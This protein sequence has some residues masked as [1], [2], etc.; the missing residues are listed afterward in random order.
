MPDQR[1]LKRLLEQKYRQYH[2]RGF[3]DS[4]PIAIPHRFTKKED[5][6]IAGFFAATIAWGNRK[7]ILSSGDRLMLLMDNAPHDFVLHHSAGD[8]RKLKT[9]GHRTFMAEDAI[10]FIRALRNIYEKHGGLE[11]TF[12]SGVHNDLLSRIVQFRELFFS[13]P[14]PLRV[15]KHVSNPLKKSTAKRICMFLRWMVREG[16]VDFGIWKSIGADQLA[17]PLDVHTGRVS[18]SLGLLKRKQNDWQS[19]QE[20][21]AVLRQFD[22]HDPVKYDFAL[23]GMGVNERS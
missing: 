14:H 1:Q 11:T 19:V 7:A 12:S 13:L 16:P 17:L 20:V 10:F 5:I 22:P 18:R 8:L 3:I 2:V 6:E 21:T 4:D 15:E 23:F 9:F